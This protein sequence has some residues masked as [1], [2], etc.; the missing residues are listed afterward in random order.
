MFWLF[1]QAHNF[2]M[3]V[4]TSLRPWYRHCWSH[5]SS[6]R[7]ERLSAQ[8]SS[9]SSWA[10]DP[11]PA[12][13]SGP[14]NQSLNNGGKMKQDPA[15]T[16]FGISIC[17]HTSIHSPHNPT[18]HTCRSVLWI[19]GPSMI[20]LYIR[21]LKQRTV[22]ARSLTCTIEFAGKTISRCSSLPVTTYRYSSLLAACPVLQHEPN[23]SK[24]NR[25]K[26]AQ[27]SGRA[28][29]AYSKIQ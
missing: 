14:G 18:C 24:R 3:S 13:D 11:C 29:Y 16:T 1:W 21:F 28:R 5:W 8:T 17:G 27:G 15:L 12:R 6:L 25:S 9:S 7:P 2:H 20:Q 10:Q 26:S 23:L 4:A 22:Y 19:R